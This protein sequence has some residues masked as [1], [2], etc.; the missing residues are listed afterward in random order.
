[1]VPKWQ[2]APFPNLPEA[3]FVGCV[4]ELVNDSLERAGCEI[5]TST[6]PIHHY[7][8]DRP[9][10]EVAAKRAFYLRLAK[11]HAADHPGDPMAHV[12]LAEQCVEQ[13]DHGAAAAAYHQA[14][15]LEPGN[16]A[17]MGELGGMLLLLGRHDEARRALELALR[18]DATQASVWR[19]LGV[20]HAQGEDWTAAA[21]CFRQAVA[22]NPSN[23]ESLR[24]LAV[25]LRATGRIAEAYALAERAVQANPGSAQAADLL[26]ELG[27]EADA[28]SEKG[29]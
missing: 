10:A 28:S 11:R 24:Y 19:N 27:R 9:E 3:R 2:G 5:T 7:P 14:L 4:H 12:V 22:A 20:L 1:M 29:E 26:A 6:I 15:R 18:L 25:A 21:D 13:G 23:S 16:A 8:L 17:W